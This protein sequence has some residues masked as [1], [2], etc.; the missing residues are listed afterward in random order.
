MAIP[1]GQQQDGTQRYLTGTGLPFEEALQKI[2]IGNTLGET[3]SKTL[4]GLGGQLR[5]EL[6]VP[7]EFATGRQL[8]TG[9]D[10]ADLHR[11][12]VESLGGLLSDDTAG[13]LAQT[14]SGT[15]LTRAVSTVNRLLDERKGA[16]TKGL[17]LTSGLKLTDVDT[18]KWKAIDAR[19]RLEDLLRSQ[20]GVRQSTDYYVKPEERPNVSEEAAQQLRLYASLK[21]RAREAAQQKRKIGVQ[22]QP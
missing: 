8:H 1:T 7:I 18:E 6:R 12:Q 15:P 13:I 16:A 21:A 20:E 11:G 9:R 2:R 17:S 5:P 10:L 4:G 22:V 3:I 14:L 19:H